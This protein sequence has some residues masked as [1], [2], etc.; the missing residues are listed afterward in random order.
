[1]TAILSPEGGKQTSM[2]LVE[3][4]TSNNKEAWSD[5]GAL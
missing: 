3:I 2:R 1:M 4:S 5:Q